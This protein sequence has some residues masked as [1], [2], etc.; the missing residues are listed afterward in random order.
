MDVQRAVNHVLRICVEEVSAETLLE[1]S[2]DSVLAIEWLSFMASG[3][4]FVVDPERPGVLRMVAYR[5]L[6]ERLT[7][8]CATVPFGTC[9][10]GRAAEAND[11]LRS[12]CS[13]DSH[14]LEAD[15]PA[16]G[17]CC[18]P[19]SLN[20]DVLGVMNLYVRPGHE[21]DAAEDSLLRAVSDALAGALLRDRHRQELERLVGQLETALDGAVEALAATTSQRDPYTSLHMERV[22]RLAEAIAREMGQPESFIAGLRASAL[23]HDIGQIAVPSQILAKPGT[24]DPVELGIVQTHPH[25]GQLLLE[26][27]PFERPVG[28]TVLQHHERL[29]GS[30]YPDGLHDGELI[31]EARILAVADVVEAMSSHRPYRPARGV[32]AA[33]EEITSHAGEKYD[34]DVVDACVR[35]VAHGG[36]G[37]EEVT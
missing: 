6:P 2:L 27:V 8:K 16:H 3:A 36:L 33:L 32:D 28:Q 4:M 35:A 9:V 22:A 34:S 1:R 18:A 24:L 25:I 11:I 12:E 26:Q 13:E 37:S 23:L 5:G 29:D 10:C 31:L 14:S 15:A 21:P 7:E 17:H 30:G 19:I 20:S